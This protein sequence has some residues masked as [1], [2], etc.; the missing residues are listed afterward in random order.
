MEKNKYN[1]D[2]ECLLQ[3]KSLNDLFNQWYKL[4]LKQVGLVNSFYKTKAN[5][6]KWLM[7]SKQTEKIG[8]RL[9][10][11]VMN[12]NNEELDNPLWIG[13]QQKIIHVA[14][15]LSL[16]TANWTNL[17]LENDIK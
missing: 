6:K 14:N 9:I 8:N 13:W 16:K 17:V 12:H 1:W 15:D 3:N 5:F 10:M 4:E 2:L 7:L 11:Y